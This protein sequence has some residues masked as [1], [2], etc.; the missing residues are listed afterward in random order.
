MAA[1]GPPSDRLSFPPS[2]GTD[3]PPP[4]PLALFADWMRRA[5][6][7]HVSFP[8][9]V[10]LATASHDGVVSSRTV[11]VKAFDEEKIVFESEDYSRKGVELAANPHAALTI[12]WREVHRQ[13]CVTGSAGP[14]PSEVS[15]EMWARRGRANQAASVVAR[16]GEALSSLEEERAMHAAADELAAGQEP[17][18][19]PASYRAY[20]LRPDTVEFWE[21]SHDR[22]HRRLYYELSTDGWRWRRIKP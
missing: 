3:D 7:H 15:D 20:G 6:E 19:R 5:G 2:W 8:H 18:A 17:I 1:A 16:E 11:L 21:G 10:T 22:L 12:Y 13:V 4:S 9:A 14:L